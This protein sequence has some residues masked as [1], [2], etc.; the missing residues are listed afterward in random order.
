[1]RVLKLVALISLSLMLQTV[2]FPFLKIMG[3][4]P[5][6][7]LLITVSIGLLYGEREGMAT[8]ILGGL[9]TDLLHGH[10]VGLSAFSKGATGFFFGY[11]SDRI[12]KD[13]LVVPVV[14][15]F[16]GTIIE[17]IAYLL[18][19]NTVGQVLPV[20][21]GAY[22]VVLPMALYDALLGPLTFVWVYNLTRPVAKMPGR[23]PRGLL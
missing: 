18:A 6:L 17:Q 7:I 22:R 5:D 12:F 4:V 13:N 14:A 10:F 9:L 8:G 16:A 20:W 2:V 11:L 21:P 19:G 15:G 3:A 1:M 23:G